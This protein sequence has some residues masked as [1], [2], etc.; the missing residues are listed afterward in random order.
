MRERLRIRVDTTKQ[1]GAVYN[2]SGLGCGM[3]DAVRGTLLPAWKIV[4]V[5]SVSYRLLCLPSWHYHRL[6][7][8]PSETT[9]L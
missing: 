4:P 2:C 3:S 7:Y 6:A 9:M 8:I 1:I 5:E